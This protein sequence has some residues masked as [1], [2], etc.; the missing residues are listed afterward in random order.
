MSSSIQGPSPLPRN[1]ASVSSSSAVNLNELDVTKVSLGKIRKA[2]KGLPFEE[3]KAWANFKNARGM[4]RLALAIEAHAPAANKLDV[5]AFL[6]EKSGADINLGDN[7]QWTPLYRASTG[8]RSDVLQYL[9]SHKANPNIP[10]KD[11]SMPIHRSVDRGNAA[12]VQD[13][14]NSG[15]DVNALNCFGTPLAYAAKNGNLEIAEIL[16]NAA[17]DPNLVSDPFEKTP[18]WLAIN[19]RKEE[20]E[21]FLKSQGGL[22]KISIDS[23]VHTAL[24]R[25]VLQGD[26]AGIRDSFHQEGVDKFDRSVAHYC[27]YFGK[28]DDIEQLR[29]QGNLDQTDQKGRTPLHYA[30]ID[31]HEATV[32]CLIGDSLR[33]ALT[34]RDAQGY[35]PLAWAC[36]YNRIEIARCLLECAREVGILDDVLKIKDNF[37]WSA[38]HKCAQVGN[39]EMVRILVE[40]YGVD[41]LLTTDGHK[42]SLDIAKIGGASDV[43]EYLNKISPRLPEGIEKA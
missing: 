13:L 31:G 36:Q 30:V 35:S 7:D 23:T 27:A 29:G 15:A 38:I 6:V 4:T 26:G 11:G 33:C 5:I 22:E 1:E 14:I 17:A 24:S 32:R 34:S 39:I 18:V 28:L 16:L 10:N 25:L 3:L 19:N 21:S 43:I 40:E 12:D 2:V 37:G 42:T 20:M 41:P 9:L 8:T